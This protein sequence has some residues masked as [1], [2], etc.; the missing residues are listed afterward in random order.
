MLPDSEID[1]L[2][3]HML[4]DIP[5]TDIA[6]V[7]TSGTQ[8]SLYAEETRKPPLLLPRRPS[9]AAAAAVAARTVPR[10]IR[11]TGPGTGSRGHGDLGS[12][13]SSSIRPDRCSA[14]DPFEPIEHDL[15]EKQHPH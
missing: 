5:A 8:R 4:G 3:K 13:S 11:N 9:A 2:S 15:F 14:T 6:F 10:D 7:D 1:W 12:S